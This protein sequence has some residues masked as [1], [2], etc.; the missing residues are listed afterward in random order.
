V[1]QRIKIVISAIENDP[2]T[3]V[4]S[5]HVALSVNLSSSRLRH[6]FKAETGQSFGHYLKEARVK[7]AQVLLRTT[8]MSVKEIMHHVGIRNQSH[9]TRD[10]KE[11][12]GLSPTQYRIRSQASS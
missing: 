10:F 11:A 4:H 7:R 2:S 5:N 6:L 12:C 9:F 1:D 8:F 3:Y